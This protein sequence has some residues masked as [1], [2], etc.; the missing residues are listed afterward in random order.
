MVFSR[1]RTLSCPVSNNWLRREQK[2]R[3]S[4]RSQK[5]SRQGEDP[6][7]YLFN[8]FL[9]MALV[10]ARGFEPPTPCSRSRCATRLRYAPHHRAFIGECRRLRNHIKW[11]SSSIF[12][13]FPEAANTAVQRPPEPS[14]RSCREGRK[15]PCAPHSANPSPRSACRRQEAGRQPHLRSGAQAGGCRDASAHP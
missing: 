13:G 9:W 11:R 6:D 3:F 2:E 8:D 15:A 10:G 12:R 1:S 14:P 4:V 5:N 7:G